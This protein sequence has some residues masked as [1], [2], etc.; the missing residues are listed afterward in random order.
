MRGGGGGGVPL[1]TLY[2]YIVS[3]SAI[4]QAIHPLDRGKDVGVAPSLYH[5]VIMMDSDHVY[6]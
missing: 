2:M 1:H 3:R 5:L 6:M 4:G